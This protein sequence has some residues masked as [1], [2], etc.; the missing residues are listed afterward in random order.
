MSLRIRFAIGMAT[1]LLPVV[2]VGVITFYFDQ[3]TSDSLEAIVQESIKEVHPVHLLQNLVLSAGM[4]V[5]DYLISGDPAERG[6]FADLSR[7]VEQA[8]EAI[9][10]APFGLTA[11]RQL[12]QS[13]Q[14][15][16]EQARPLGETLLAVPQ[17]V[18]NPDS[19][20]AM[21]RFDAHMDRAVNLLA[22]VDQLADG[23]MD[24]ALAQVHAR[25][26]EATRL[27]FGTLG[28]ALAIALAA[29]LALAHSVLAPV[30]A[31][32]KGAVRFGEG[33]LSYRVA[34]GRQ[35]ELGQLAGAFNRAADQ[36]EQS[37]A[38]LKELAIRDSLT[39]LYTRREFE[40]RLKEEAERS[41]RFGRSFA[42]LMLDTDHFKALN[43]THGHPAGDGA[44]RA[45]A[46]LVSG[47][48]RAV[49][50]V[51]R[52]GGEEFAVLLP[53]TSGPGG[54]ALAERIRVSVA[55]QA[56][57]VAQGQAGN[58]TV[59]IGV[60][61]FP[62]IAGSEREL[63]AAA[64]GALYAAKNAGRNRVEIAQ[65]INNNEARQEGKRRR[66]TGEAGSDAL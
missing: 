45:V 66:E 48:V 4:P 61:A 1:M 35:D 36:V 59:S 26:Q 9:R 33:D 39:G 65:G 32:G 63:V 17:P 41:R 21:K 28:V 64:D 23:E 10:A 5:H 47:E 31:I 34:L 37:Q 16:W 60:A 22:Q 12:T 56:I 30:Y 54:L 52:Y 11:E 3:R 57:T 25:R 50:T 49:D 24:E 38:A 55:S 62:E 51:A 7:Q 44:L 40:R 46:A 53:E 2:A 15:E 27:V 18:G 14:E 43:D 29:A 8:F 6:A 58:L 13:A 20:Q 19:P 42:L